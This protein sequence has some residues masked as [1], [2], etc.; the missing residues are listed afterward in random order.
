MFVCRSAGNTKKELMQIQSLAIYLSRE[1]VNMQ[2]LQILVLTK[3]KKT[4]RNNRND[5]RNNIVCFIF[6]LYRESQ[7]Q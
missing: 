6:T 1:S 3:A 7:I 5:S 2:L 4:L